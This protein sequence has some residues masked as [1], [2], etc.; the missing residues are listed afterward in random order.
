MLN[1]VYI[2]KFFIIPIRLITLNKCFFKIFKFYK[3][4][5]IFFDK[6]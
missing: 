1:Y 4:F 5:Y 2:F 6:F 3:I